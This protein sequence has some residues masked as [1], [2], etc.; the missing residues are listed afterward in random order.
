M[1]FSSS[2]DTGVVHAGSLAAGATKPFLTGSGRS[3][4]Q[5]PSSLD[6][7]VLLAVPGW[8]SERRWERL[9]GPVLN[10]HRW[11]GAWWP[12]VY[13]AISITARR[14]RAWGCCPWQQEPGALTKS[15]QRGVQKLLGSER[16]CWPLQPSLQPLSLNSPQQAPAESL[17]HWQARPGHRTG[18]SS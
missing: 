16:W 12:R 14:R 15:H 17:S 4:P 3:C 7:S 13:H 10:V 1:P 6:P 8:G 5:G 11:P 18:G 9:C 2:S